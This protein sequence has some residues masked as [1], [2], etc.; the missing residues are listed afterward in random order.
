MEKELNKDKFEFIPRLFAD[1][2]IGGYYETETGEIKVF[3]KHRLSQTD[4]KTLK[5][6]SQDFR[7]FCNENDITDSVL[8][9]FNLPLQVLNENGRDEIVIRPYP[10]QYY[11][12]NGKFKGSIKEGKWFCSE[13]L[14]NK[15]LSAGQRGTFLN[16][17]KC[18]RKIANLIYLF[19]KN[20]LIVDDLSYRSFLMNP[21]AG[22][23]FF[24]AW[25]GIHRYDEQPNHISPLP[26]FTAPERLY[27]R[28]IYKFP[29]IHSNNHA[30]SVLIYML[31]LHRHP[32][33][34]KK[35]NSDDVSLDEELTFGKCAL[36]IEH[37]G[38][39]SN[40]VNVES[41]MN[42]ELPYGNPKLRPYS[43]LGKFLYKLI[44]VAFV[45]ALHIPQS[46]PEPKDWIIALDNTI[47]SL[48]Q[49]QNPYC[50]EK[51][52]VFREN[53]DS[54]ICPYCGTKI[55]IPTPV[56]NCY[57]KDSENVYH[58]DNIR[59]IGRDGLILYKHQLY[60]TQCKDSRFMIK[61]KI[62]LSIHYRNGN[63][64]IQNRDIPYMVLLNNESKK[65][66]CVNDEAIL[67]E[68]MKLIINDENGKMFY[69]Q[70]L[71]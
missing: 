11:F 60:D 8:E 55:T 61:E 63:W 15:F 56:L 42:S 25:D 39:K 26:D 18:A 67:Q 62:G 2:N 10:Q 68:S 14:R 40:E 36:F 20:N 58:Y 30:L 48:I 66:L 32:L 23:I 50:E 52:F 12:T 33:R 71:K 31:L 7:N 16:H 65:T 21:E 24:V 49:C 38:D 54:R 3:F 43:L 51:Y 41:L 29:T 57:S 34:G 17:L 53:C 69:V 70:F 46:R 47:S 19:Q 44:N 4:L 35:I 28:W 9:Q 45:E 22:E 59:F 64:L 27:N 1:E 5:F 13:K 6:L 37:P